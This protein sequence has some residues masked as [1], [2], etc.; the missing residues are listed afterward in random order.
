VYRV[1]MFGSLTIIGD[2]VPVDISSRPLRGLMG[3]FASRPGEVLSIAELMDW[4]WPSKTPKNPVAALHTYVYRLRRLLGSHGSDLPQMLLRQPGYVWEADPSDI[5][6][7]DFRARAGCQE[8]AAACH[9]QV[10]DLRSTLAIWRQSPL[11][12]I[13]DSIPRN[14][15]I[16]SLE[17]LRLHA[18]TRLFELEMQQGRHQEIV[19]EIRQALA[20]F[21]YHEQFSYQLMVALR[22]SQRRYDALQVF[23]QT[24][25][26]LK[27]EL[28]IMPSARLRRLHDSILSE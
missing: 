15:E 2:G 5:D 16:A 26:S 24:C 27:S 18:M 25:H 11:L 22:Q 28:G 8:A 12:D 14:S 9:E 17:D 6:T 3:A 21:P 13:P 20:D 1:T 10:A 23:D 7:V 4:L 19:A